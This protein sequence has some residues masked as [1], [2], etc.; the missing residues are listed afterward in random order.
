MLAKVLVE[1]YAIELQ[2]ARA[3]RLNH[4]KACIQAFGQR[5]NLT[6]TDASLQFIQAIAIDVVVHVIIS[7]ATHTLQQKV[8][9]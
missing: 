3:N 6:T 1:S 8:A 9:I 5:R 7:L 4:T 2:E